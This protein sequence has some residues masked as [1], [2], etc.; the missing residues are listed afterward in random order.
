MEAAA[1]RVLV[2]EGL[3]E[4]VREGV[5]QEEEGKVAVAMEGVAMVEAKAMVV[6]R[7]VRELEVAV[8]V[9]VA[10]AAATAMA[11]MAAGARE[12]EGR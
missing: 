8:T 11:A 2:V 9:V 3:G 4:A 5:L 10:T 7:G 12:L 1:A 6:R